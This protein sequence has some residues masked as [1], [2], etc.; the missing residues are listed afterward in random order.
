[1]EFKD[2][3]PGYVHYNMDWLIGEYEKET[4]LKYIY[5]WGH[6]PDAD[7]V[8][9]ECFS[10]WYPG[11]FSV[12]GIK[13]ETAEHWMMAQ[14]A[15]LFDNPEIHQK[16]VD[17]EKPGEVKE[18][19]RQ[20]IGFDEVVWN[21]EKYNIVRLGNIHKFNQN[22]TLKEF[23]LSSND[24]V[25]I[26]A[27]P[28]DIVWGIGLAKD[29]EHINNLYAWPGKNLLGFALMEVRDFLLEFGDVAENDAQVLPP[30]IKFPG[31]HP[32]DMFFR[33]GEGE[34]YIV[35]LSL[36]FEKMDRRTRIEYYL[37]NPAPHEWKDFYWDFI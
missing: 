16:I 33:M 29:S 37:N 21:A 15:L 28:V 30:W 2:I 25:L 27:S 26:E 22:K 18:L 13:Y 32:I 19:G 4:T 6:T 20:I 34:A 8:G 3:L 12:N 11:S 1:M 7:T 5:F 9:K 17:S 14:K 36:Q 10:Q 31:K 23:L 35:D 24:R